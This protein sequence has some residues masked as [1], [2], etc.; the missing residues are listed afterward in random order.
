MS[1]ALPPALTLPM[2]LPREHQ[3]PCA[4]RQLLRNDRRA[5]LAHATAVQRLGRE[6]DTGAHTNQSATAEHAPQAAHNLQRRRGIGGGAVGGWGR[7][8]GWYAQVGP[9]LRAARD[10]DAQAW[11]ARDPHLFAVVAELV[12]VQ[13]PGVVRLHAA[14]GI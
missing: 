10:A 11:A 2:Y 9:V 13:V 1:A 5:R 6:A 14:V 7:Q 12:E 3:T 4:W 8:P